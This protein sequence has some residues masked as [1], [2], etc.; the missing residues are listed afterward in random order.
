M[1]PDMPSANI[2]VWKWAVRLVVLGQLAWPSLGGAQSDVAF[3]PQVHAGRRAALERLTGDAVIVVPGRYMINPGDEPIR[4]DPNFWYLTGVE[5]PFSILLMVPERGTAGSSLSLRWRSYLFVPE[6]YQYAGGQFPMADTRF[7]QAPWNR[8]PARLTPGEESARAVGVDGVFPIDS[9][10]PRLF[11]F[12]RDAKVLYVPVDGPL[13]LPANFP[14]VLSFNDGFI[15]GVSA[16]LPGMER[17]DLTPL[18]ARLRAVKDSLEVRALRKAAEISGKGM[19][20][21]MRATRPG[22]RD[23]EI[24]G[25]MEF[26]WKREGSP[27]AAFTPI[28]SSGPDAMTL[29]TLQRE[30]Y[31]AVNHVMRSGE[32]LFVDYGAAEWMMYGSDLCRTVPV[33]GH[34]TPVQRKYY[35]VVLQAQEAAIAA[36]RPGVLM[37]DVIKAAAMV[38]RSHGLEPNEDVDRMGVDHVWGIMPSPTH[39]LTRNAG[40]TR[41]SAAGFG[42]R[43]IGH[44]VGLEATDGR[45]WTRPLEPGMVVTVEPK[46][47][48]PDEQIAIM[49]EDEILVTADGHDNLSANVPKRAVDIERVMA[50]GRRARSRPSRPP[51]GAK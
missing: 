35:D 36:I 40:V 32:L 6:R 37:V 4:Q 5:S 44:H 29:F 1:T 50:E 23:R 47:Y 28:V 24:A 7:R 30:R 46:L 16:L 31:N 19:V 49:I 33:S 11:D 20:E 12:A 18:M 27:R 43:D 15:A 9:F 48:I 3:P 8:P 22:M 21:M 17:R 10:V 45:D 38:F 25:L 42:V 41:Y 51:E 13:S 26:V 39:Y 34:F 2:R 14:G